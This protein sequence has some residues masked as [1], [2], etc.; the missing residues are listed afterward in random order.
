MSPRLT[1]SKYEGEWMSEVLSVT[2]NTLCI[3][4]SISVPKQFRILAKLFTDFAPLKPRIVYEAE[5]ARSSDN[6]TDL[7]SVFEVPLSEDD[8]R[9]QL[10][11]YVSPGVAIKTANMSN[12]LCPNNS[13]Y[14]VT[15]F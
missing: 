5:T 8:E 11:I 15:F 3:T 14:N 6:T 1:S 12:G 13:M 2:G 4:L 9:V 7:F 10:A